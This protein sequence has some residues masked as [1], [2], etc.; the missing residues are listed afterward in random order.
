MGIDPSFVLSDA[1][2]HA[3]FLCA[4][5]RDLTYPADALVMTSGCSH[6]VCR[7]CLEG[8]LGRSREGQGR[9][10]RDR[11]QAD[12]RCP[13][14]TSDLSPSRIPPPA[15]PKR[16]RGSGGG[17]TMEVA[18]TAVL[19]RPLA[20][21]QPLAYRLLGR[22]RVRCPLGG[23]GRG[24]GGSWT[25]DLADLRTHMLSGSET[26][27][28]SGTGQPV[29][30][31]LEAEVAA[32]PLASRTSEQQ[33]QATATA[34]AI[35]AARRR[36][37]ELAS[38]LKDEANA[39]YAAGRDGDASDLYGRAL[40]VLAEGGEE[41][42]EEHQSLAAVLRCNRAA[43]RLRMGD[44]E[45]CRADCASALDLNPKYG[46]AR[47]RLS[48]ALVELGRYEEARAVLEDGPPGGGASAAV[49]SELERARRI[50]RLE[51]EG[52]GC[53]KDGRYGEAKAAYGAL[54]GET[55]SSRALIGAARSDLGLGRSD[56]A[57]RLSLR[58]L[59]SDRMSAG[60]LA[61]RGEALYLAGET[62][63]AATFLREALRLDPDGSSTG[64]GP[65][66][67]RCRALGRRLSEARAAVFRRDFEGAV[68][69]LGE[70]L[71]ASEPLPRRASLY[72]SLHSERAEAYLRL[73]KYEEAM[74][75]AAVAIYAR[76]DDE[77]AWLV[78]VRAYHGLERHQDALEEL[79]DLMRKWGSGNERI[80][81]AYDKADFEVR[82]A[83]RPDFYGLLGVPSIAS[84]M[85]IKKQYKV[86]AME[87]HP[88]RLSG[89]SFSDDDRK[90]AETKFKLLGEG[91]E[92]LSDDF[93]R[94]LWDE[95]YDQEAIRERIA[96]AQHAAHRQGRDYHRGHGHH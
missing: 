29:E 39:R 11:E 7:G 10:E 76:D 88:D 19:V 69:L 73:K 70:A 59:R 72:G 35:P 6:V 32:A 78:K 42:A 15:D 1:S 94:Q 26:H 14:C 23:G 58:V 45:G 21:A 56:A 67:K 52:S 86:K 33:A 90:E 64:A 65:V 50:C 17:G 41:G 20:E 4:V 83:R 75:D 28:G 16:P 27:Q 38:S 44:A 80:R 40:A 93:K 8:W 89:Q 77:K 81:Q 5:C 84:L 9:E 47:V 60:G 31:Q 12:L 18:G 95:G 22:V 87:F 66:L 85:E 68:R 46:K 91:L 34:T 25:G 53:L 2:H 62:D 48:R 24:G 74:K 3:P 37:R 30:Q 13:A 71:D 61:V 82:K 96:A 79:T 55:S 63:Q 49:T 54:L 57:L 51:S 36:E 43:A 92:M